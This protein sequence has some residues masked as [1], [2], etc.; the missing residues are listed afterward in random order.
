MSKIENGGL[1]QYGAG[2]FE[3]QQCGTAGVERVKVIVVWV[4]RT[5]CIR[6]VAVMSRQSSLNISRDNGAL[7]INKRGCYSHLVRRL[8]SNDHHYCQWSVMPWSKLTRLLSV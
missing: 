8:A 3:Q 1:D 6:R 5:V 2:S 7:S 4:N